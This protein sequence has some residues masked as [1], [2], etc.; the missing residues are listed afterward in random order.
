[1]SWQQSDKQNLSQSLEV[2]T[3]KCLSG[4]FSFLPNYLSSHKYI[5][6]FFQDTGDNEMVKSKIHRKSTKHLFE[7][8]RQL[9]GVKKK[10]Q[11]RKTM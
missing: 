8:L 3:G 10:P 7:N 2:T 9:C 6:I 11:D 5:I 4:W 1:M